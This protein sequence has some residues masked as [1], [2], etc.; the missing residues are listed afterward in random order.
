LNSRPQPYQNEEKSANVLPKQFKAIFA[1]TPLADITPQVLRHS[2]A[3]LAIDLGFTEATVKGLLGHSRGSVTDRY[4]TPDRYRFDRGCGY[5]RRLYG[6]VAGRCGIQTEQLRA[7]SGIA[8][9]C[10]EQ[11]LPVGGERY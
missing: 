2:F 11:V 6:R 3:T 8:K 9:G 4:R 5:Y 1:G 7:G 10:G